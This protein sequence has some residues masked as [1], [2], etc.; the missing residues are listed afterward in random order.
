MTRLFLTRVMVHGKKGSI[1]GARLQT[2]SCNEDEDRKKPIK[3]TICSS[4][5][6]QNREDVENLGIEI[7]TT[8]SI[9]RDFVS[10]ANGR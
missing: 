8:A 3:L 1:P 5:S 2:S 10:L 4:I 9:D 6:G 7:G